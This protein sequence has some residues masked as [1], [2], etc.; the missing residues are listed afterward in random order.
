[1]SDERHSFWRGTCQKHSDTRQ[2]PCCKPFSSRYA[3]K[4]H[5]MPGTLQTPEEPQ[6]SDPYMNVHALGIIENVRLLTFTSEKNE[7][8]LKVFSRV[9]D[10]STCTRRVPCPWSAPCPLLTK[11]PSSRNAPPFDAPPPGLPSLRCPHHHP[12]LHASG[13]TAFPVHHGHT[14]PPSLDNRGI[15]K[16][17]GPT[18]F[19]RG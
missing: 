19:R 5:P 2:D 12:S 9:L 14:P 6:S 3:G 10:A 13:G 17:L 4:Q 15:L 1:M 7:S 11:C 18:W 16:G 8:I